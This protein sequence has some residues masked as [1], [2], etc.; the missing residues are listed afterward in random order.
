MLAFAAVAAVASIVSAMG[1]LQAGEN[2][3][4]IAQ[5]NAAVSEANAARARQAAQAQAA[6]DESNAKRQVDEARAAYAAS[7]VDMTGTPLLVLSD[8]ATQGELQKQLTLWRGDNAA[9]ARLDQAALDRAQGQAALSSSR[10][11]AFSGLLTG[12]ARLG[13]SLMGV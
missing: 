3:N 11:S 13:R 8:L 12:G 7:G 1:Q 10:Y 6:L 4:K 9:D 2:A 5:Y